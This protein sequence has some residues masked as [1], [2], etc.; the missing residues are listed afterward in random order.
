M[1]NTLEINHKKYK[2][3]RIRNESKKGMIVTRER[4]KKRE[5]ASSHKGGG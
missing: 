1:I 2:T 4:I 3:Q 5:K